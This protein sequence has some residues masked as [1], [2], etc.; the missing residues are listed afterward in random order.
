MKL[1]TAGNTSIAFINAKDDSRGKKYTLNLP[2]VM[3]R[4]NSFIIGELLLFLPVKLS[5]SEDPEVHTLKR[6]V[7]RSVGVEKVKK[8]RRTK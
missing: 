6:A 4:K 1:S 2:A 8:W 5:S 3:G 7:E